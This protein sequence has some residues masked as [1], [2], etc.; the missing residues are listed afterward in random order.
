MLQSAFTSG[1]DDYIK[2]PFD[3]DELLLRIYALVKR[4]TK[5]VECIDLLCHDEVH[6]SILYNKQELELSKKEYQLLLLLMSH[7]NATVPKELIQ[8]ELWNT[9]EQSSDGAVRVYINRIKH[10]L[11]TMSIENVRGIGYKLVS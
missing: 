3:N 2:K 5:S 10:L 4:N 9:S 8:E 11:P 1:A 7:V 6:K